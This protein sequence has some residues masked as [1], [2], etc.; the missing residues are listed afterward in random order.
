METRVVCLQISDSER[1]KVWFHEHEGRG[2]RKLET[3]FYKF[4]IQTGSKFGFL[5][6]REEFLGN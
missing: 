4:Q 5:N 2:F 3:Y 1:L 6:T